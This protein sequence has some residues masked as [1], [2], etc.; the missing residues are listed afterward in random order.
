MANV[1]AGKQR[2][3]VSAGRLTA[4]DSMCY[5][6]QREKEFATDGQELRQ[7][8][9]NFN[10]EVRLGTT[11]QPAVSEGWLRGPPRGFEQVHVSRTRMIKVRA[12]EFGG[13]EPATVF[14]RWA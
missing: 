6:W 3:F 8:K 4:A 10:K 2:S 7:W 12:G 5:R 11:H 14:G 1:L 9:L 13:P